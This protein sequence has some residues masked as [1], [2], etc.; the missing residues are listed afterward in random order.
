MRAMKPT[1]VWVAKNSSHS[2]QGSGCAE[3]KYNL[4]SYNVLD[5]LVRLNSV[6]L[7]VG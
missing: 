4:L 2:K 1:N 7:L 6:A 5:L 3:K